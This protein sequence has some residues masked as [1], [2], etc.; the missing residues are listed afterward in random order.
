MVKQ[1]ELKEVRHPKL[2][3]KAADE[4]IGELLGFARTPRD[5]GSGFYKSRL[6]AFKTER[7][8]AIIRTLRDASKKKIRR[9]RE[10]PLTA[11]GHRALLDVDDTPDFVEI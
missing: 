4:Y 8:Q 3:S 10:N 9:F 6:N 11:M 7:R 1:A 5:V 2:V